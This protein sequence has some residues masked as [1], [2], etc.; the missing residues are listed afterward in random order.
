M[1]QEDQNIVDFLRNTY[2]KC[3]TDNRQDQEHSSQGG[4]T[5]IYRR[6]QKVIRLLPESHA[7]SDKIMHGNTEDT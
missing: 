5:Y 6:N 7:L 2:C 4:I 3:R 1:E